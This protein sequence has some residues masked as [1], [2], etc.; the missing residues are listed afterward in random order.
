MPKT[1]CRRTWGTPC[2]SLYFLLSII[3][4]EFCRR[5]FAGILCDNLPVS[6]SFRKSNDLKMPRHPFE[7]TTEADWTPCKDIL[8][9]AKLDFEEI[10]SDIVA[11]N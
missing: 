2:M 11:N 1:K 4:C 5:T 8:A 7:K 3:F 10:V 9:E 6:M